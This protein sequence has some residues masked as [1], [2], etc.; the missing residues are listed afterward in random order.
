MF[1]A[2]VPFR[3]LQY[4]Q[5]AAQYAGR[6]PGLSLPADGS[7]PG[8]LLALL[9]SC[10]QQRRT[11]RPDLPAMRDSL[12]TL[13]RD[14]DEMEYIIIPA[15]LS[16]AKLNGS[17]PSAA[18]TTT[19]TAATSPTDSDRQSPEQMQ[20]A[21]VVHEPR[22]SDGGDV[23]VSRSVS[24][25]TY[26]R[27]SVP[28]RCFISDGKHQQPPEKDFSSACST[29]VEKLHARVRELDTPGLHKSDSTEYCSI[30]SP[31]SAKDWSQRSA[32][33]S[34]GC[35]P[36]SY[37]PL[38]IRVPRLDLDLGSIRAAAGGGGGRPSYNF[39]VRNYS[40]PTT[41]IARS[42]KLRKN[43]WLSGEAD[44]KVGDATRLFDATSIRGNEKHVETQNTSTETD[45]DS[46]SCCSKRLSAQSSTGSENTARNSYTGLKR[47]GPPHE[48][49][50]SEPA[51]SW[52]M[53]S[54][55]DGASSKVEEEAL[56]HVYVKPLVAIHERWIHEANRKTGRSLS[57]PEDNSVARVTN[58]ELAAQEAVAV[59]GGEAG[60]APR[61]ASA[62]VAAAPGPPAAH[63]AP[64]HG[65]Q[66][67]QYCQTRDM[68]SKSVNFAFDPDLCNTWKKDSSKGSSS[69]VDTQKE[70]K[71]DQATS[72]RGI[73][74]FIR[75]LIRREFR[76]LVPEAAGDGA[77]GRGEEALSSRVANLLEG[78]RSGDEPRRDSVKSFSR[79][80]ING[81]NKPLLQITFSRSGE[82]SL[83]VLDNCVNV[84]IC[85]GNA[86]EKPPDEDTLTA[87]DLHV[88]SLK[89]CQAFNAIQEARSTED[90]YID[91]DLSAQLQENFGGKV[92]LIP[93][94]GSLH[95]ILCEKEDDCC[96]IKVKQENGCDTIYFRCDGAELESR[97][98]VDGARERSRDTVVFKRSIS[99]VEERVQRVAPKQKAAPRRRPESE[100]FPRMRQEARALSASSPSLAGPAGPADV[101]VNIE[102]VLCYQDSSS[103]ECLERLERLE[104]QDDEFELLERQIEAGLA[105]ADPPP[106]G[107]G[108]LEKISEENLSIVNEEADRN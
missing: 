107:C 11:S 49:T 13:K 67:D 76:H 23:E 38:D 94:H 82:N 79:V 103:D 96:L 37:R 20:H 47:V 48:A 34:G 78:L 21:A 28:E 70:A 101:E 10:L 86:K 62:A 7:Y 85:D 39:D 51:S 87:E 55:R 92:K 63:A 100:G 26:E 24:Y 88:N 8:A 58:L 57:L 14:L 64:R 33:L 83:Q 108:C 36:R 32:R 9:R 59:A 31:E 50:C 27:L 77:A 66:W 98:A 69:T 99:L 95:E 56:A 93:L 25:P 43:A 68:I 71:V 102:S 106:L 2:A 16:R 29:P 60:V 73:E 54:S 46:E 104:R 61:G 1:T 84:T 44:A 6:S 91:D 65:F 18:T 5:L 35:T 30:L 90:L 45:A 3:E 17:A 89:R 52:S 40:L 97:D 22:R 15:R 72:T 42:N 75:D 41:P 105:C 53:R 4:E 74:D 12:L 80:K 19:I 81:N